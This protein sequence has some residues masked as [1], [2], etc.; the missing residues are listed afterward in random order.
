M[1]AA[2]LFRPPPRLN[3][4]DP[5]LQLVDLSRHCGSRISN[6]RT[7]LKKMDIIVHLN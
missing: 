6:A 3:R 2:K 5:C 4:F 1:P 7:I